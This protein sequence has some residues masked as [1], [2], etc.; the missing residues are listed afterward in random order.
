MA[1]SDIS[2]V[3]GT[4]N[5][6]GFSSLNNAPSSNSTQ[7]TSSTNSSS[8]IGASLGL[9]KDD[10]LKLFMENL[11]NQDPASPMD[12]SQMMQQMSQLGM[13]E[14][15]QNLQ[16]IVSDL[17]KATAGNQLEQASNLLGKTIVAV[18]SNNQKVVGIPTA[19]R[20]NNG[21]V[22]YLVNNKIINMGQIQEIGLDSSFDSA[23]NSNTGTTTDS[24]TNTSKDT[25]TQTVSA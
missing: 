7:S 13:M 18:D 8:A 22:E 4:T 23:T 5:L 16:S 2:S 19:E 1:V 10:F 9:Q 24:G 25:N 12:D 3:N 20:I 21:V 15:I 14:A 17:K 11:K 6:T